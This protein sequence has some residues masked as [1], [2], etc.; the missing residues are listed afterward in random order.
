MITL[1]RIAFRANTKSN[2]VY[3]YILCIHLS[4][5][6]L[7]TL[8][9]GA[10]QFRFVT[11]FA[12]KSPPFL[13]VYRS[14]IRSTVFGLQLLINFTGLALTFETGWCFV[15]SGNDK[16]NWMVFLLL[17]LVENSLI[18]VWNERGAYF[19]CLIGQRVLESCL[20]FPHP[21]FPPG[22]PAGFLL[23]TCFLIITFFIPATICNLSLVER[24]KEKFI[25]VKIL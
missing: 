8:E 15:L 24:C 7:S 17:F 9:I 23:V 14:P 6:W 25:Q 19:W 13:F 22:V 3:I 20:I 10:A 12:P 5:M 16:W 11:E 4:D 21:K 2:P 18:E 1:H